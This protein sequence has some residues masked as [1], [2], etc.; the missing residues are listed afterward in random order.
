MRERKHR[1][2]VR[3]TKPIGA[4]L[5]QDASALDTGIDTTRSEYHPKVAMV[6]TPGIAKLYPQL[7]E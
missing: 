7:I 2:V 4:R 3:T 1:K 6:R 5:L